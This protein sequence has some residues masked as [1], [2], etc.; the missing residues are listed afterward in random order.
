MNSFLKGILEN[1]LVSA[2]TYTWPPPQK[3]KWRLTNKQKVLF[4]WLLYAVNEFTQKLFFGMAYLKHVFQERSRYSELFVVVDS[5]TNTE[6]NFA[7]IGSSVLCY[8]MYF[9]TSRKFGGRLRGRFN[10]EG[11][12]MWFW[13][14][15][16]INIHEYTLYIWRTH[17]KNGWL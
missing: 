17:R 8:T 1:N 5:S 10:M 16:F 13:F 14:M 2:S 3:C 4:L 6:R 9:D 11:E 7:T 12:L 15:G